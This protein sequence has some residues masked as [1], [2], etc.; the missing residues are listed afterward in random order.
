MAAATFRTLD[1]A[2]GIARHTSDMTVMGG[3]VPEGHHNRNADVVMAAGMMAAAGRN[4]LGMALL[5]L[6]KEWEACGKPPKR[7]QAQIEARAAEIPDRKG[8]PDLARA[9]TEALMWHARAMRELAMKLR[10][11]TTAMRLLLEWAQPRGIDPDLILPAVFHW[12]APK[13]PACNG[14]G[15]RAARWPLVGAICKHC[16]GSTEWPR[17]FGA[18]VIHEHIADCLGKAKSGMAGKLRG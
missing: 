14:T 12:L 15:R 3:L 18:G 4:T 10:T 13:C 5:D 1:E 9:E 17:P 8:R 11:R 6:Q 16:N 2:Y 7:S